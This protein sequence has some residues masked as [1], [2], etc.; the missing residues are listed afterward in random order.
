M[1]G[2][3][4]ILAALCPAPDDLSR[5]LE[6]LGHVPRAGEIIRVAES[7]EGIEL[8]LEADGDRQ[9]RTLPKVA[10]SERAR[11]LAVVVAAWD[12]ELGAV[13]LAL[14]ARRPR[15]DYDVAAAFVASFAESDFAPAGMVEARFARRG[16]GVGG[17]FGLLGEGLRT[18]PLGGATVH[19]TRAALRV[20]VGYRVEKSRF[21]F[22]FTA[23]PALALLYYGGSGFTQSI[24]GWDVDV[25][26]GTGIRFGVRAGRVRPFL[27]AEV[28]GWLRR[29]QLKSEDTQLATVDLPQLE[30]LVFAGLALIP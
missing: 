27:G 12:A 6:R 2:L 24:D 3:F 22:D 20:G 23:G 26:L 10:C 9:V 29:Q 17:Y 15:L 19:W 4:V 14:P 13:R 16:L 28:T 25:A 7:A 18:L 5:E 8:S 30:T 11:M 21:S 1:L